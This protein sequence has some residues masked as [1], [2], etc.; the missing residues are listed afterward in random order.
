M[1]LAAAIEQAGAPRA[2]SEEPPRRG[3]V[4]AALALASLVSPGVLVAY[5]YFRAAN[6]APALSICLMALPIV[7]VMSGAMLGALIGA[8]MRESR[9]MIR[10]T[11]I[12][13]GFGALILALCVALPAI[14]VHWLVNQATTLT[15]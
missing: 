4:S 1:F 2:P 3:F 6:S 5:A 10:M 12:V 9:A 7:A 14:D 8:A 11:S 15:R 13:T